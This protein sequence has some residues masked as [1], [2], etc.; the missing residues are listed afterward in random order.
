M[1]AA[2]SRTIHQR[3]HYTTPESLREEAAQLG[4]HLPWSDDAAAFA[5]P[6]PL[7][8]GRILPNRCVALPMEGFDATADGSPTER[9]IRR[10]R[11]YAA[12][13]NGLVWVEACAI[14][15][16]A[17]T[18]PAQFWLHEGNVEAF[19]A[20]VDATREA[21]RQA[22]GHEP[23]IVLQMTHSGRFSKPAGKPAPL[24]AGHN[25]ALDAFFKVD[26]AQPLVDDAT[27][28]ALPERFASVARLAEQAGFD[29]VDVKACHGYLLG[30]LLATRERPGRYGGALENR[31][32][33]LLDGIRAVRA[34]TPKLTVVSRLG[35]YDPHAW[36][37]GF[38]CG[39]E[40]AS[41]F[42]FNEPYALVSSMRE[43]GVSLIGL[44]IGNPYFHPHFN[45]PYDTVLPGATVPSEH[46]MVGVGRCLSVTR[47]MQEAFPTLPMV[48]FGMAWLRGYYAPV[49][50]GM[51]STGGMLLAGRGR[52]SFSNPDEVGTWLEGGRLS[53]K[54]P[55]GT[56]VCVTCSQC[57]QRM[58]EGV[59]TGCV[60]RD[61]GLFV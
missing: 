48:G 51:L 43:A 53:E 6:L 34:A 18:N 39:R 59:A 56:S 45:R 9:S 17:R 37:W 38:G 33:P 44:T 12:G 57:T 58:R 13:G 1:T 3:F 30:E 32:R 26:P 21:G 14:V 54:T 5:Q 52:G 8:N 42:D 31:T 2:P 4:I 27:L 41:F 25:P 61:R 24:I 29:A 20:L 23:F 19:R 47:T 55:A 35:V 15:P 49:A 7:P 22:H 50:A 36:P 11:R 16:E 60:I 28:D 10:Y 46:P 40:D